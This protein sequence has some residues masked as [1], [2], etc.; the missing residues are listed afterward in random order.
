MVDSIIVDIRRLL[1]SGDY[2]TLGKYTEQFEKE[3][4]A[5]IG[6]K[7]AIAMSSGTSSLE[8]ILRAINVEG[9]EVIIPTNT[10]AAT[11]Y[12][13]IHAGGRPVLADIQQDLSLNPEDAKRKVTSKTA[14]LIAVHIGGF[15]SSSISELGTFAEEK[16]IPLVEDAAHAHGS[17]I[18]GNKA[19]NLG[20]AAGFSFFSTKVITCGEGG[21]ITTDND[22]IANTVRLLR[23]QGKVS[24]NSVGIIGYNW[25]M[26]EFQSI[27]GTAQLRKIEEIV[28]KRAEIAV[29]YNKALSRETDIQVLPT[30]KGA[31][32]NYYKYV[33]FLRIGHRPE[34]LRELMKRKFGVSLSGYVYEAPLHAQKVFENYVGDKARY[35]VAD[36]LCNRHV[37]LPLYPQMTGDESD[38]VANSLIDSLKVLRRA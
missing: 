12:A 21:M 10:F 22:E 29:R 33:I 35:E 38:Y 7:H 20:V 26:S 9:R 27:V 18:H 15:I 13:V 16:G 30:P 8:A 2:L 25:R 4:A 34:E 36:D 6:T 24:G 5:Y 3:F 31:R 32:P 23:D 14:A 11:A 19:G 1:E 37:C 17:I 28:S